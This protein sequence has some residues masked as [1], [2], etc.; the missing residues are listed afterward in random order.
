MKIDQGCAALGREASRA[1][2][3]PCV[4]IPHYNHPRS[5]ATTVQRL[6]V[7]DVP[8]WITDDGSE[9]PARA[10]ARAVA[11]AASPQV[12]L[13]QHEHNFG[14]GAAVISACRAAHEAGFTHALQVDAD[15]QHDLRDAARLLT[16]ARDNPRA[17]VL[18]VPRF[19]ASVPRAR[20]YGRYVT[21]AWVW[22][23]TL[24]LAIRDSM[25]G[26]RVYPL[27]PMLEV[28]HQEQLGMRMEFDTE[29]IVRMFWRGTPV[30][31]VPTSVSYPSDGVSHFRLWRDNVRISRM[32]AR[33]FFG[34]LWRAPRLLRRR[35]AGQ[36][37][38][39]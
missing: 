20:L 27:A 11:D 38:R 31:N 9:P 29:V 1:A 4:V 12:R 16:L 23:H 8:V 36:A 22:I 30:V 14:K 37:P 25:C 24:S 35:A 2:F 18:G 28:V 21:H 34:M 19:D 15:G 26:F 17:L 10:E 7:L 13:V 5:L 39:A 32:H 3:R 6:R 33:L